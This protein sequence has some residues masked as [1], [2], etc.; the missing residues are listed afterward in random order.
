MLM[1]C[2]VFDRK[3]VAYYI[4]SYCFFAYTISVKSSIHPPV[5]E[6]VCFR[7]SQAFINEGL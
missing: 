2:E 5:S 3:S 6:R 4:V 1:Y 7:L